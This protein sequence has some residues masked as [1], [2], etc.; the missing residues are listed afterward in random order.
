MSSSL[1]LRASKALRVRLLTGVST[2]LLTIGCYHQTLEICSKIT[3]DLTEFTDETNQKPIFSDDYI[4]KEMQ[5]NGRTKFPLQGG[6]KCCL[7]F[8]CPNLYVTQWDQQ[9]F[10]QLVL[11]PQAG[12]LVCLLG[13]LVIWSQTILHLC[14]LQQH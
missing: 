4:L 12:W 3:A 8:L 11:F 9:L 14:R 5:S 10:T 2:G 1:R 6:W 7:S 13:D